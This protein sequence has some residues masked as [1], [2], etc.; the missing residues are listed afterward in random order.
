MVMDLEYYQEIFPIG[1]PFIT[2]H[3]IGGEITFQIKVK[4]FN[5]PYKY[6]FYEIDYC[7]RTQ[8]I[9]EEKLKRILKKKLKIN[10]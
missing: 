5:E 10:G 1:S 4:S 8:F 9:R 6:L 3:L 2:K 7:D